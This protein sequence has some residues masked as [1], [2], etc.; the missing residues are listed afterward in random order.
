MRGDLFV[1]IISRMAWSCRVKVDKPKIDKPKWIS[2]QENLPDKDGWYPV[3]LHGDAEWY[4]GY[5]ES[6][7]LCFCS[8]SYMD[9]SHWMDM[10]ED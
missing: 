5:Y 1:T 6:K 4:R 8:L 2:I 3:K 10:P 7:K 9:V